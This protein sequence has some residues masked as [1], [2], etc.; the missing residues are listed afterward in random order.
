MATLAK[1]AADRYGDTTAARFLRDGAWHQLTYNELWERVRD[2]ALGL[3]ELG[4]GVGDRVAILANTRLEFTVADLAAS[5]AGAIVVPVYPSNSPDECEW[6]VGDSGSKVVVCENAAQVAKIDR[7]RAAT[8]RRWSTSSSSTATADGAQTIGRGRRARSR[9]RR[10]R[11]RRASQ[12]GGG[13][14][15]LPDHLHVGDD[16][17]A[18]GR[19]ADEP[20]IRRGSA[21]GCRGQPV[22]SRRPRLP[23]PTAGPRVR[24]ARPGDGLRDRRADRLLGR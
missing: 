21:H 24:P 16:G 9:S 3:V 4:V 6:V 12:P 5:T 17:P 20:R 11:A 18:Q 19:R 22:R 13:R 10:R 15:R 23:V 14:R 1:L 8:C 2:L 7:R